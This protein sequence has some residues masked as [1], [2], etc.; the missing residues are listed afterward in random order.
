[1]PILNYTTKID[2]YKTITEIHKHLSAHGVSKI[3]TDN[4]EDGFPIGLTFCLNMKEHN[5][6]IAFSLPCNFKGVLN[7]MKSNRKVP[8]SLCNDQQAMRVGWRILKD[9][10][11][12]QM[13]IVEA[14]LATMT[15]V[16][17]PYA[18][19]NSGKTLYEYMQKDGAKL[20]SK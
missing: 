19:T 17:L 2:C 9:W 12:A 6:M 7:S 1:M 11:E 8:R 16:F 13:A 5:K 20:L 18:V 14:E 15:E 10:I 4:N 3:I